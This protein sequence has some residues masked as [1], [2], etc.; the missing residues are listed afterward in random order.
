MTQREDTRKRLIAKLRE[1]KPGNLFKE[2]SEKHLEEC[3]KEEVKYR[4]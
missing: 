1:N 4:K 3:R 2:A